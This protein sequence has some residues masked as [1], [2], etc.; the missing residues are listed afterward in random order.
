MSQPYA[1]PNQP[2]PGYNQ[3]YPVPYRPYAPPAPQYRP[4]RRTARVGIALM[5]L[6][7]LTAII[8][9]V[10]MWRSYDDVKRFVYGL[11]SEDEVAEAVGS[12]SGSGPLLNL[13]GLLVIGAGVTFLIWLS[14]ARE[15]T[16]ALSP[17][18]A[19]T[20][21][22][23]QRL[24]SGKHRHSQGWVIGSWICPVV[25]FWY[26]L[27]VVQ[28]VVKASEP[29]DKPGAAKSGETRGLLYCW[30]AAWT[31]FWVIV[32]GGGG[33]A[34][35]SCIVWI[36]RLVDRVDAAGATGDYV[37][38]YDL[39]DFMVRVALL[40]N[41]GF[42]VA[43]VLLVVAGVAGALLMLRVTSWQ[44]SRVSA[45]PQQG[46]PQGP[47]QGPQQGPPQYGPPQY[48]PRPVDAP[49]AFPSYARPPQSPWHR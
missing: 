20:Y 18:P 46:P 8:Q 28:D 34:L 35:V 42:S 3:P 39:Q 12:I 29:T 16:E 2:Y 6:T 24:G 47:P 4:L 37:D 1:G 9:S 22:G 11:L 44:D 33:V 17:S 36:V 25:Q 5:G 23:A 49:P 21:Q 14:Q 30:W 31:G 43:T 15:N 7:V 48:A 40:V 27:Q 41:V 38:I 26:P 32:V 45:P 19:I 10:L 13:V